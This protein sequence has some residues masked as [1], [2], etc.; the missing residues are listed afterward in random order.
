[1]PSIGRP[2]DGRVR[3]ASPSRPG[4]STRV[5]LGV[6][7]LGCC[8]V[9][10]SVRPRADRGMPEPGQAGGPQR[11]HDRR[12]DRR[13]ALRLARG[14]PRPVRAPARR[15]RSVGPSSPFRATDAPVQRRPAAAW[16]AEVG[17]VYLILRSPRAASGPY[18]PRCSWE[19]SWRSSGSST[20]RPGSWSSSSRARAYYVT[21]HR[22][23]PANALTLLCVDARMDHGRGP[24][25]GRRSRS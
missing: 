12:A 17:I 16:V 14:D 25:G 19:R 18:R 9:A 23:L 20:S 2:P 4:A 7:A 8:S 24:P 10:A 11:A 1:M 22:R 13:R 5:V 6:A 21:C 15:R 3:A